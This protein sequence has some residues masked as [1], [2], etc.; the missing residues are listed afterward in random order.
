MSFGVRCPL[1]F[2]VVG[3]LLVVVGWLL[4]VVC[5]CGCSCVLFVVCYCLWV[6]WCVCC[7]WVVGCCFWCV[8]S[9]CNVRRLL[10]VVRYVLFV[11][12]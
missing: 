7:L 12:C 6:D 4:F 11:V 1:L 5:W 9:L 2:T 10:L 3:C 8:Q